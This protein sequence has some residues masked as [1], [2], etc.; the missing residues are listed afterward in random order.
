MKF[1]LPQRSPL[2]AH[3]CIL[4]AAPGATACTLAPASSRLA[5][6]DSPISPAPTTRHFRPFGLRRAEIV[7]PSTYYSQYL[8]VLC[9]RGYGPGETTSLFWSRPFDYG[10]DCTQGFD[11]VIHTSLRACTISSPDKN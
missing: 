5:I 2:R 6:F 7:F 4:A 9:P 1:P 8:L 10:K 11:A 3:P